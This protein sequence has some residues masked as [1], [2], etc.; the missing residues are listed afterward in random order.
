M[1]K[2][3]YFPYTY[4][5]QWVAETLA[6][7]FKQFTVYQPSGRKLPS[8]MQPWIDAN[9]MELRVPVQVEARALGQRPEPQLGRSGSR[10][11]SG[12]IR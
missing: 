9:V 8:E 2:P 7:C 5:P 6:A 10:G 12:P 1:V 4:V 3:I 11:Q